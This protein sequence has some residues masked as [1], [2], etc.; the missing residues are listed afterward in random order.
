MFEVYNAFIRHNKSAEWCHQHQVNYRS[1]LRAVEIRNQLRKYLKRWKIPIISCQGD[2]V[3]IRKCILSGY[4]ANVAVLSPD[5]V[6]RTIRDQLELN[7]HPNSILYNRNPEWVVYHEVVQT[8]KLQMREVTTIDPLW[9][10]DIAPHFY[11]FKLRS[12]QHQQELE[13]ELKSSTTSTDSSRDAKR[14]RQLF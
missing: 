5:G 2:A 11:E 8:A 14:F 6:Y 12:A 7:I 3:K 10:A 9:L 4:F 1:M 13:N